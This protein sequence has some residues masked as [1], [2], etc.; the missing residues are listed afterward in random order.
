MLQSTPANKSN[1]AWCEWVKW[2][3]LYR[4]RIFLPRKLV[5]KLE[6][7]A[8]R[9]SRSI[10]NSA[11]SVSKE[12]L[13]GVCVVTGHRLQ[14]NFNA[15][16]PKVRGWGGGR[17]G[18]VRVVGERGGGKGGGAEGRGCP[19]TSGNNRHDNE[20]IQFYCTYIYFL[21]WAYT[22][23][24]IFLKWIRLKNMLYTV[25]IWLLENLKT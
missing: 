25:P 22:V 21:R 6:Q 5:G 9:D 14:W 12:E 4:T 1:S 16:S 13:I 20:Q 18:E 17:G 24:Q 11:H 19:N 23:V 2:S 15:D 8:A 10:P 7:C 3:A